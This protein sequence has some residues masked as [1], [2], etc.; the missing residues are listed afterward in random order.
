MLRCVLPVLAFMLVGCASDAQ[1]FTAPAPDVTE[2]VSVRFGS[3]EIREVTLPS[4]AAADEITRQDA[5][6]VLQSSTDVL[7]ADAPERAIALELARNLSKLSG[8]RVASNPWPFE[9]FPDARLDIRFE[10]LLADA[11][12]VY[13]ATGQ[14]FVAVEDGR[15]RAGLFDMSR[16]IDPAAGLNTLAAT[17]KLLILDVAEFIARNGLG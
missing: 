9:A 3:I 8:A 2:R 15:E 6:G 5:N 1:L 4:Y 16:P 13:R 14:F 10:E 11:S 12:G 17:R 7:W